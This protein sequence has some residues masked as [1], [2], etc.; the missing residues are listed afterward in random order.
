MDARRIL[1]GRATDFAWTRNGFFMDVTLIA[2]LA[3]FK[4][5]FLTFCFVFIGCFCVADAYKYFSLNF[6]LKNLNGE[7][8]RVACMGFLGLKDPTSKQ[9]LGL[10]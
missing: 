3:T 5:F 7:L 2:F 1:H 9:A 4:D 6:L 10:D 8:F